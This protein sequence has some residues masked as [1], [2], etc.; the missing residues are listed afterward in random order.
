MHHHQKKNRCVGVLQDI[1]GLG[2]C[3]LAAA[4]PVLSVMGVQCCPVPT[5]AYTNQTGYP[6]YASLD[7]EALLKEFITQW[8]AHGVTLD[9][10]YTG[11]MSSTGQL[12]A[13]QCFIDAFRMPGTLLLID[14]V[15]GDNGQRY[16]CFDEAFCNAVRAF[17]AG[18]DVITP[19]V[20]EACLLTGTSYAFFSEQDAA[21]Q[22]A[23]LRRMCETLPP[24][25]I[26][27]TGWRKGDFV[28]NAAWDHGAFTVQA[29]PAAGGSWS[30]T[31][32]L[33]TSAL[34]GGLLRGDGL[35]ACVQRAVRFLAPALRDAVRMGLP[36]EGG[37]PFELH[38]QELLST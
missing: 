20:T 3:S 21:G 37:I 16:P 23:L 27:I 7:C 38:L 36:G 26:V 12:E 22:E 29:S 5:A 14:P 2:R 4:L 30:G 6:S 15:M 18:A 13:V 31:G 32:D 24:K 9:G 1:S 35:E 8:K 28:C 11:F 34:C 10:I 25:R 19:N 17:A 33:F